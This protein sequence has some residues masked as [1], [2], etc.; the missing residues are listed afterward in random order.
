MNYR[1]EIFVG[2]LLLTAALLCH[3]VILLVFE[4]ALGFREFSDFFDLRKII[5]ALG[6]T[7]WTVGSAMHILVG[8]G[9]LFVSVGVRGANVDRGNLI[10]AFGLMAA[11]LFVI[12]GMSGFVGEQLLFLLT[13]QVEKDAAIL[14]L[15]VGT[16]TAVLY[17][18]ATFFGGMILAIS[19]STD[20]AAKW[21]RILGVPIGVSAML[22]A[23]IPIPMPVIL[24]IWSFALFVCKRNDA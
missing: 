18:A 24:F 17:S 5:P 14:G 20:F 1:G 9:L 22:F 6:S 10:Q 4:P 13:D 2:S 15:M 12:V 21:L 7:A 16:R 3:S 23:Y 8:F 11:P 19:A